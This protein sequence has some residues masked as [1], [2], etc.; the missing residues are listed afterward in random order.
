M[1]RHNVRFVK[2]GIYGITKSSADAMGCQAHGVCGQ[3]VGP[4][5]VIDNPEKELKIR[6]IFG[7]SAAILGVKW[8]F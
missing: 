5:Q 3:G 1:V 2:C 7:L 6:S 4:Q 8:A